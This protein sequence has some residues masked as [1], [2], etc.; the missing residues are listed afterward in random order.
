MK[1]RIT[2][3]DKAEHE[4]KVEEVMTKHAAKI[5]PAIREKSLASAQKDPAAFDEF[6]TG[7]PDPL[8]GVGAPSNAAVANHELTIADV[9]EHVQVMAKNAGMD[10]L[11]I[12]KHAKERG[13]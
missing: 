1:D 7:V 2:A 6:M 8:P 11:A 13:I 12:Y 9:P 3:L 5:P 10:A 4:R